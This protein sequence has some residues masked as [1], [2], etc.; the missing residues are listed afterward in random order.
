MGP[1]PPSPT[2]PRKGGGGAAGS[3][4]DTP[5]DVPDCGPERAVRAPSPLAGEGLAGEGRGGGVRI[6]DAGSAR[7]G[8]N[9]V[10]R[11]A[12]AL[13]S[14]GGE[15]CAA[16]VFHAA[17]LDAWLDAPPTAMTGEEEVARLHRMVAG[18]LPAAA[19]E[20]VALDAGRRTARYILAHR[21]PRAAC[22]LLRALPAGPSARL[23]IGA[24][25]RNAWTFAGSGRF[26]ARPGRPFVLTI[27]A[28]P[29]AVPGCAWHRGVFEGLFQALVSPRARVSE[30]A[31]CA[32]GA[33]ACRFEIALD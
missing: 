26:A 6:A 29:I 24:I 32:L 23:L 5:P 30:G 11:M 2:L 27:A 17:G 12:E 21:I 18:C 9:A 33:T 7:I 22:W 13:R 16:R 8:P 3:G 25:G 19:A 15:A 20:A 4:G 1:R 31:C 14:A 10:I 28:N